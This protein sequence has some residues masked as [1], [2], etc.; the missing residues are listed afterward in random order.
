VL[1]PLLL[2][3]SVPPVPR[4]ELVVDKLIPELSA[5]AGL[6]L[7]D[8]VEQRLRLAWQDA[9]EEQIKDI[10]EL[11]EAS[12]EQELDLQQLLKDSE[13]VT[14]ST[15]EQAPG[16]DLTRARA[17]TRELMRFWRFSTTR[18]DQFLA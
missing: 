8:T 2:C 16:A 3:A 13:N 17:V 5:N 7:G 4:P 18:T 15:G 14:H 10:D 6:E 1:A 9:W 11:S 12:A